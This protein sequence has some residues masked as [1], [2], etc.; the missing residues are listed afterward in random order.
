VFES[1]INSGMLE[2]LV[3]RGIEYVFLSNA[4]NLG[5]VVDLNI[6]GHI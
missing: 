4:D 3:E 5:A 2:K 1:M 6:L